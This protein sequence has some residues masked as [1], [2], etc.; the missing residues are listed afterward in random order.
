MECLS[1]NLRGQEFRTLGWFCDLG[2]R[3]CSLKKL[4]ATIRRL[5]HH[6]LPTSLASSRFGSV[7]PYY[8]THNRSTSV[9]GPKDAENS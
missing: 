2:M 5:T 8:A 1:N 7:R 3:D 9:E 6:P 4:L